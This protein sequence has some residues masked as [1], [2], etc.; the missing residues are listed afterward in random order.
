M[1]STRLW[2][3]TVLVLLTAGVLVLDQSFAPWFPFLFAFLVLTAMLGCHELLHL[4]PS[5]RR[6]PAWFCCLAVFSI[7]V[8]NWPAHV[9]DGDAWH[10][11]VG[12]FAA[13][14]L[15]A[16]LAEMATFREPGE[17]VTRIALTLWIVTYLGLLPSFFAQ[18]RWLKGSG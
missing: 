3:G 4:L 9:W 10:W 12:T 1:L 6:P 8:A 17:S 14:V 18:L 7:I 5:E 15:S 13:V 2:M 11:V 16:F